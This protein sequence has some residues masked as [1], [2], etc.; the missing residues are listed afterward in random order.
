MPQ[1][2]PPASR[3][4]RGAATVSALLGMLLA[5]AVLLLC[6][7]PGAGGV[8]ASEAPVAA[9]AVAAPEA[10]P[11]A[12]ER[13]PGCREPGRD[14][15]GSVPAAPGRGGSAHELL[16]A[17]HDA[18]AG[19]G[20]WGAAAVVPDPA[21]GHWTPPVAPPTPMDLSILRV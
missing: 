3:R 8:R 20:S 13:E 15:V 19:A 17:L 4:R 21:P 10:A 5:V 14:G 16:P 2:R 12:G 6:T 11:S 9:G 1:V 18:R 7:D